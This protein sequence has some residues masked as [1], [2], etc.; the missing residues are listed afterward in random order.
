MPSNNAVSYAKGF[1]TKYHYRNPYCVAL[2]AQ[3]SPAVRNASA[4][5]VVADPLDIFDA[6]SAGELVSLMVD[7]QRRVANRT[8]PLDKTIDPSGDPYP[9]GR[10]DTCGAP[11]DSH[12]C[13]KVS[14]HVVAFV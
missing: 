6:D 1:F 3:V 8:Y 7:F 9:Y 11:C 10:C 5:S 14:T 13:S 2:L 4:N 12:G